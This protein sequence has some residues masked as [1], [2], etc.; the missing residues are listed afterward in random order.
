MTLQEYRQLS[1]EE[2]I[3][4][5]QEIKADIKRQFEEERA[6]KKV[7][8]A[9]KKELESTDYKAIKYAEGEITEEQYAPVRLQRQQARQKINELELEIEEL[10]GAN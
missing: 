10:K 1:R 3:A 6:N 2:I 8:E 5:S 7:I 4:L 9:L